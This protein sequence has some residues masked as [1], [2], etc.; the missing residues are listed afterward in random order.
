MDRL[1]WSGW[2]AYDV[3]SRSGGPVETM[4]AVIE[5]MKTAEKLLE[6]IGTAHLENMIAAGNPERDFAS[7]VKA[8][9]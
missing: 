7:L 9:L 6:K 5:I 8:L 4:T 1:D 3:L 2:L